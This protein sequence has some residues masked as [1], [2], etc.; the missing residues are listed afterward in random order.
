MRLEHRSVVLNGIVIKTDKWLV[1]SKIG[2][3]RG[4]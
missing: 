3:L 4:V 2:V 1:N